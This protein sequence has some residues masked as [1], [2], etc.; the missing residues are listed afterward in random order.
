MLVYLYLV[1]LW[2]ILFFAL[3]FSIFSK[4]FMSIFYFPI[5]SENNILT[6]YLNKTAHGIRR[7][8]YS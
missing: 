5:S 2:V 3:V 4:L 7:V 6:F 1:K 8:N